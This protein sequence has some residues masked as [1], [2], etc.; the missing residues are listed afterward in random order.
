MGRKHFC[1]RSIIFEVPYIL[2]QMF[3]DIHTVLRAEP[4]LTLPFPRLTELLEVVKSSSLCQ[5]TESAIHL[6]RPMLTT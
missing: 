4:A 6:E 5:R 2:P 1:L 3:T